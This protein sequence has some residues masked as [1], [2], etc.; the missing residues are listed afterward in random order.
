MAKSVH[1]LGF[2]AAFVI[3]SDIRK[4]RQ[5]KNITTVLMLSDMVSVFSSKGLDI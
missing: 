1:G 5:L 2:R 3:V 4:T